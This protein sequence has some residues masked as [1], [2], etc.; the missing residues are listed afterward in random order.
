MIKSSGIDWTTVRACLKSIPWIY[1]IHGK[2]GPGWAEVCA[3]LAMIAVIDKQ[4]R[5]IEAL[6]LRFGVQ[7]LDLFGSAAADTFDA[8][9]SDIDFLVEFWDRSPGYARRWLSLEEELG[10][11]FRRKVDL[12]ID[13]AITSPE[14]RE[15]ADRHRVRVYERT[16]DK[17][18]V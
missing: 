5:E 15:I 9:A 11:L 14:F 18:V 3:G 12:V 7:W 1:W 6:S 8:A 13:D 4:K 10:E 2:Q 17:A 16:S